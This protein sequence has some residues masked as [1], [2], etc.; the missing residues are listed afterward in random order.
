M[1]TC[2]LSGLGLDNSNVLGSR[3]THGELQKFVKNL[4]ELPACLFL[5]I[6]TGAC[7]CAN[8]GAPRLDLV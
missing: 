7:L 1:A 3:L 4:K 8:S 6:I 2:I 5:L